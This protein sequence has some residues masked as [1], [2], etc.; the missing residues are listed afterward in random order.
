MGEILIQSLQ[1]TAC[2]KVWLRFEFQGDTVL[3]HPH[4]INAF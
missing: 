1:I 3:N 4:P 2:E